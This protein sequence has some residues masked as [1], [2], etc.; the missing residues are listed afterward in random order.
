MGCNKFGARWSLAP[1]LFVSAS[2]ALVFHQI[3]STEDGSKTFL[4][5]RLGT[6]TQR[7]RRTHVLGQVEPIAN[8]TT[9]KRARLHPVHWTK[10]DKAGKFRFLHIFAACRRPHCNSGRTGSVQQG[11]L[12]KQQCCLNS[13]G[14]LRRSH[15]HLSAM[16]L[17]KV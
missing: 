4:V 1:E 13:A 11:F 8:S 9:V 15:N 16:R 10:H 2:F 12:C 14:L 6:S 3:D 17:E 7:C 5:K